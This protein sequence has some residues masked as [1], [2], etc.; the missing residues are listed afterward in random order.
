MCLEAATP[1]LTGF[2]LLLGAATT[3]TN[4]LALQGLGAVRKRHLLQKTNAAHT[5]LPTLLTQ[6][7]TAA[8]TV[9]S[10]AGTLLAGAGPMILFRHALWRAA[11]R[12]QT[13]AVQ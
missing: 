3:T 4:A 9:P 8:T 1:M 11:Q 12:E 10:A 6:E 13:A 5:T 2:H 7:A